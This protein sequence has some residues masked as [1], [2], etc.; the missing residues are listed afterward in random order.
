MDMIPINPTRTRTG[1]LAVLAAE[2]GEDQAQP[3]SLAGAD[4]FSNFQVVSDA[5][6]VSMAASLNIG[7][8]FSG[9][10]SANEKGFFFDAMTFTDRYMDQPVAGGI[11]GTRWGIGLR[12]LLRVRNLAANASLNFGMVGAA[13][14]LNM[15]Q[16]RYEI[17]GLGIGID[18]LI[19]V[20]E[21]LPALGDF[22]Y[23]TYLMLNGSVVKKLAAYIKD[24]KSALQPQPVA[25]A[26]ARPLDPSLRARAIYYA[27]RSI[28]SGQPLGRAL[29]KA[30]IVLDHETIRRIYIDRTGSDD[31]EA[32]PVPDAK[33]E[34][35]TWLRV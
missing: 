32:A 16:A 3:V 14:E 21:E 30:P 23:E 20:L 15:A 4:P 7:S 13:V 11:V 33:R 35:E 10:A 27:V 5:L 19:L 34:A 2:L 8:I 26:V 12:V 18:G 28:A 9:S 25:V 17:L 1:A 6:S 29:D 24:N 31:L 22:K